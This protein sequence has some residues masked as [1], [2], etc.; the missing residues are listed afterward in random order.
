VKK[1]F[2]TEG[3][4]YCLI[5]TA[6]SNSEHD[7][8][9]SPSNGQ[10]C[11]ADPKK[12]SALLEHL[13]DEGMVLDGV[14]AQDSTQFQSLWSI[15]ESAAE[16]AGKTGSVYKYDV[17]VPVPKMYSLVEKMRARLRDA[18]I[19]EG[20]GTPDGAIRALAGYGHMGDGAWSSVNST[21]SLPC[22]R[23]SPLSPPF[24]LPGLLFR[25]ST[26][27]PR[28]LTYQYRRSQIRRRH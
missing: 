27:I 28:Q 3:D 2:E 10:I 13:M 6:G 12:L 5:E 11:R 14:L 22:S 4:F 25:H 1:T 17:S 9:V 16:A 8:E 26:L 21:R 20:D 19:M 7:E 18:G 24:T 23:L 15:R